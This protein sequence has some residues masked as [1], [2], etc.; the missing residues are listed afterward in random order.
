MGEMGNWEA[1]VDDSRQ[2]LVRWMREYLAELTGAFI[3]S[4]HQSWRPI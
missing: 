4:V 2:G 3:Y 1:L